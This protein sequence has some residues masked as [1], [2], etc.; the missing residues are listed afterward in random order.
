[1]ADGDS[2]AR[3]A[4]ALQAQAGAPD[5]I[6]NNAGVTHM[7]APLEDVSEDDFD[8]VFAVNCK[9]VYLMARASCRG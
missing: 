5:I 7:P 8:R 4:D 6:V 1:M 2:V 3:L 9:S